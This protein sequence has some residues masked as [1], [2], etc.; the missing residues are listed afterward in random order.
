MESEACKFSK[1]R[2]S[3]KSSCASV[4]LFGCG[5]LR[6]DLLVNVRSPV[7]DVIKQSVKL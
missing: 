1:R 5:H 3:T 6:Y 7:L 2:V 4:R